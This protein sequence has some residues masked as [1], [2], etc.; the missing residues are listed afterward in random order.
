MSGI[1]IHIVSTSLIEL[2]PP[3][4]AHCKMLDYVM[5]EGCR[6]DSLKQKLHQDNNLENAIV[7]WEKRHS[8]YLNTS[9]RL[10]RVRI[11]ET[12]LTYLDY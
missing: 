3:V 6:L 7:L 2:A 10:M 4:Y 8:I 5:C 9:I 12:L 11:Y 1:D